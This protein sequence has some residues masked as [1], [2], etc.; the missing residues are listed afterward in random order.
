MKACILAQSGEI[1][2][3]QKVSLHSSF[4]ITTLLLQDH[5]GWKRLSVSS[6]STLCYII[7]SLYMSVIRQVKKELKIHF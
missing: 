3:C 2:K 5:Q 7:F 4:H 6:S 1:C